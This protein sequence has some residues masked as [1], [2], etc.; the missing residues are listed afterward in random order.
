MPRGPWPVGTLIAYRI[1]SSQ[2]ERVQNSAIWNKYV[3]LRVVKYEDFFGSGSKSM[4][5]CLYDWVGD[6]IPDPEIVKHLS[7]TPFKV[8]KPNL[9]GKILE[10]FVNRLND[11]DM[12]EQKKSELIDNIS[13]PI[14]NTYVLL[15]GTRSKDINCSAVFTVL[16]KDPSFVDHTPSIF[17]ENTG[18]IVLTH[19]FGLDADLV[20]RFCGNNLGD[21][22]CSD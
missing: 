7:F 15:T 5:V 9:S 12:P 18:G 2:S 6:A 1:M 20:N 19:S 11:Q 16:E 22:L 8:K 10:S 13:K 3:L 14:I 4:A 21:S 17:Y